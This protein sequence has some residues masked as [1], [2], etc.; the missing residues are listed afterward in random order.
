M[1]SAP[2]NVDEYLATLPEGA[3]TALDRLRETIKAAAPE[4]TEAISYRIP[5][6]SYRGHL[7]ACSAHKNH[8][9][10]HVMSGALLEAYQDELQAYHTSKGTIR[11]SFDEP[12]PTALVTRLVKARVKENEAQR[13]GGG[14]RSRAEGKAGTGQARASKVPAEQQESDLPAGLS[15]PAQRALAAAGIVRLEQLAHV[16]EDEVLKLHGMGPKGIDQLRRALSARGLSFA[17]A[18]EE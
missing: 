11:F 13:P 12:L 4:A 9:S 5:T 7:V 16:G 17:G 3:R 8:Y 2:T 10:L 15:R 1:N 6:F 14:K 18:A